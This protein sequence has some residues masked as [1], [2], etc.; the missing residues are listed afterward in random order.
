MKDPL[1]DFRTGA[2]QLAFVV[3]QVADHVMGRESRIS[4]GGAD[5]IGKPYRGGS[6]PGLGHTS[7]CSSR[8]P[9]QANPAVAHPTHRL[10]I[11]P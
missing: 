5:I 4:S 10:L 9:N 6:V 2:R 11:G 7:C 8:R 3:E 1:V